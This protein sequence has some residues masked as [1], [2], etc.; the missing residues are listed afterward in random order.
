[1]KPISHSLDQ[2]LALSDTVYFV[3]PVGRAGKGHQ[4]YSYAIAVEWARQQQ[5]RTGKR[6]EIKEYLVPTGE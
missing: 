2:C 1:M 6:H 5:N 4:F 3:R